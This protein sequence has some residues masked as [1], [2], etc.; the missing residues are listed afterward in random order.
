MIRSTLMTAFRLT[1]STLP[2]QPKL[3]NIKVEYEGTTYPFAFP[4]HTKLA[5]NLEKA[6]VPLEF[7]CGFGCSCGTC[8]VKFSK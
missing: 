4:L 3:V 5:K 8:A 6:G 7:E 1:T 2:K